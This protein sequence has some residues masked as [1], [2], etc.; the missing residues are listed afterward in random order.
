MALARLGSVHLALNGHSRFFRTELAQELASELKAPAAGI[1]LL[2]GTASAGGGEAP[3]GRVQIVGVDD[4]FWSAGGT[5]TLLRPHQEAVVLNQRLA[6]RLG[7]RAGDEVVLRADKPSLL[8][9]DAPL[10]TVED[11]T[12]ALRLPVARVATDAE[13]GLFSL[14]ANQLPAFN[15]FVPLR[16]LQEKIALPGRINALL[17]AGTATAV[18]ANQAL[19]RR[20]RLPD[21]G[22]ELRELPHGSGVELRTDR[23]FLDPPVAQA[24]S[25]A[26]QP[27]HGVLTYF[28]NELR[29]GQRAI[30]YSTVAALQD[31]PVPPGMADDEVLINT[32]AA[33]DLGAR[34]GDRL[35][36]TYYVVGPMRRMIEQSR[37]FRVRAVL[38]ITGAA[39]DPTLMPDFPGV[40]DAENCR[41][42]EPGIPVD[43]DRIRDKDEQYWDRYRG[44]PKAFVTLRAGQEMWNNR[45]GNLTALRYP[46]GEPAAVEA[47]IQEALNPASIGLFFVPVRDQALAASSQALDFGQLFLGFSFFLIVAALLL[48]A[49][50]FALGV[51]QRADEIGLLLAI[52]LPARRVQRLL[53]AEGA[54]LALVAGL[55]GAGLGLLYTRAV[56]HGLST[57]WSGA[58]A[59]SSLRFAATP[60]TVAG[61]ALAGFLV[62]LLAIWLVARK[63]ARSPA[64]VL[65]A[66]GAGADPQPKPRAGRT[67]PGGPT[68]VVAFIGSLVLVAAA[69]TAGPGTAAGYFF[70]AGALLLIAAIAAC[71]VL[72]FRIERASEASRLSIGS[73]GTRNSVRRW[74]RSLSAIALLACGSFLVIA[75]GANRHDPH[76]GAHLRSSGTGGFALFGESTLPIYQDLNT[77]SGRD[78]YGLVAEDLA[79]AEIVPLRLR[80]GDE[81]SCLNLNRAQSPR[82][83]GVDPEA[84]RKR[85][86]FTF[87]SLPDKT[88][89]KDLW[90]VLDRPD[91]DGAIPAVGDVNTVVWSLGKSAGDVLTLT[92]DHGK[93]VRLRIAGI[94]SNSVLQGGLLISERSF[95]AHFPSQAGYQVFL[96]DAPP[97]AAPQV[98]QN[99]T[100]ALEDVGMALIPAPERLA[101][102]N[103]VENTYLSIFA[104]LGGLG[105]MLGSIGL[106]VV[107]LR[108]VLERRGE[109]ALLRAVGFRSRLLQWLVFSEHSLLLALGLA[110]G[111]L[112]ALLAVLPALLSPGAD[113]PYASLAVTL[114]A[115]LASGLIWTW[116]ATAL[117]LRGSLIQALRNE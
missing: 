66:S 56:I 92:D 112:A 60:A 2:R 94:L 102:F 80:E 76:E 12:V 24:A 114:L 107:V 7:V 113:V 110:A 14:E 3:A 6:A 45:F 69:V 35:K 87:S 16:Y 115:V 71:R 90:S 36:L 104:I 68:A 32:W 31:G 82:I 73:L 50:L 85:G 27:A 105:L 74:G 63:Q 106:G 88:A 47:R 84:L 40:A 42:W 116:G 65:L 44:T 70:G 26:I 55:V 33:H 18:E 28:V 89:V 96:I 34:P 59:E 103:T 111:V 101:E 98:A 67:A 81:A 10:S 21:A 11:T 77:Q 48:T 97:A 79:G 1:V 46:Q 109:L 41:D 15:A 51:E 13:F 20:F 8:S 23:V 54:A 61:G 22:L 78:A 117:A 100:R 43:L 39:A 75:V 86:A 93:P 62:A 37:T 108:N 83:L 72:L 25:Q 52:G 29:V 95:I 5:T 64:R 30:P 49:L 17:V 99:L 9:R 4:A 38:P 57:V 58:V 91:A 53:L 19:W